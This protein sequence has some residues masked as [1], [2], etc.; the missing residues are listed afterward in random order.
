M[1]VIFRILAAFALTF[2]LLV[3]HANTAF[4]V[5]EQPLLAEPQAEA[6]V[7]AQ[8]DRNTPLELLERQGGWVRARAKG[9]EG[10]VRLLAVR[11]DSVSGPGVAQIVGLFQAADAGASSGR[12]VAVAGLRGLPAARSSAHALILAIGEYG[13]GIPLL[14]GVRY[15]ADAAVLMA[16]GM[17]VPAA[18]I[19]VLRDQELT[20]EG[21]RRAFD[22]LETKVA[23]GD[24]VFI[25]YSGHGTR[26]TVPEAGG[27]RC[28]D[29]LLAADG[30]ALLDAELETRLRRLAERVRRVVS[31]FDACHASG[32]ST[33]ALGADALTPKFWA[34]AGAAA[35]AQP[36]NAIARLAAV[37]SSGANVAN[38]VHIAA[39]RA[40][41]VAFDDP[42]R[43]GLA[44]QAWLECLGGEARDLDSSG[45]LSAVELQHC[46]QRIIDARL[47]GSSLYRP[48]HIT[49]IGNA[50]MVFGLAAN[51]SPPVAEAGAG[52]RNAALAALRDLFA[53]RD[54]RRQIEFRASRDHVRIG[55]DRVELSLR[56]SH[57][58]Y[59]YILMVGSDGASFDML[60]PN[61]RDEQNFVRAGEVLNLPRAGWGLIAG[62]PPGENH[63]L[64]IVSDRPRDFSALGMRPV[65][66]FSALTAN[67]P[68]A[69]A[70][71]L[72]A[73]ALAEAAE[74]CAPSSGMRVLTLVDRCSDAY[75]A[76]WLT[77]RE[78]E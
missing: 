64:A 69:R 60:F 52:A 66:P 20:L 46:A 15:D 71:L 24:E 67:R 30:Q 76:A 27:E 61:R 38:F 21:L 29:A 34:Q 37:R 43:G 10:W 77:L 62:G 31:F 47:A 49:V 25:Y 9:Q 2:Y 8:L 41:E 74:D 6:R 23:P 19:T 7:L 28:A 42:G 22:V 26:V 13:P 73:F 18:N 32:V 12:L 16:N 75:G 17:G 35:C 48:H 56:S 1:S 45:G 65:G 53:N 50:G 72:Q 4:L 14:K 78:V 5:R 54:D 68:G 70:D 33:R 55:R 3:V 57:P 51:D 63:L 40:D 59:V 39:A 44:T 58:G 11:R 36:S